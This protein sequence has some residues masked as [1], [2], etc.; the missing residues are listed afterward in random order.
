MFRLGDE[1]M[2]RLPRRTIGAKLIE[3]EQRWLPEIA[4]RLSIP[5]PKPVRTGDPGEGYP[6]KWS[7]VPWIEGTPVD[8]KSLP[9]PDA[10]I[11]A[12]FLNQLH[13]PA[14]KVAPINQFRG[15]PLATR[16]EDFRIRQQNIKQTSEYCETFHTIWQSGIDSPA[17]E[18]ARWIHGDLHPQN[19]LMHSGRLSGV[20]DWGDLTAGDTATDLA[21]A[22]MMFDTVN[23]R[24]QLF[25]SY[26]FLDAGSVARARAWALYFGLV[27]FDTG[28]VNNPPHEANGRMILRRVIT[29]I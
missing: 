25:E 15:V 4:G 26:Q 18:T 5:V 28:R 8:I 13:Q 10:Q 23:S 16:D 6:W 27:L 14:P 20:I 21:V 1:L 11:F 7:I 2:V 22:W 9:E 19:V 24:K 29:S 12:D 17:S 3:S